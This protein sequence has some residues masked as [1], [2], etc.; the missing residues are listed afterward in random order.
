MHTTRTSTSV[1][2][3]KVFLITL[4]STNAV[5]QESQK[6]WIEH[7]KGDVYYSHNRIEHIKGDGS[8]FNSIFMVTEEGIILVDPID[9]EASKWLKNELK[10]RFDLPVRYIVYSHFHGDHAVGAEVFLDTVFEIY[11]QENTAANIQNDDT[12]KYAPWDQVKILP[13]KTYRGRTE[14]SLGT[15]KVELLDITA[16]HTDD[17]T[18]VRFPDE[19]IIFS[20]DVAPAGRVLWRYFGG[21]IVKDVNNFDLLLTDLETILALDFDIIAPGH[22]VHFPKQAVRQTYDYSVELCKRVAAEIKAGRN[23][24]QILETVT[25]ED[26]GHL[27]KYDSYRAMN[28]EGMHYWLSQDASNWRPRQCGETRG[29]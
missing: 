16:S 4:I 6:R 27:L 13:T 1:Q 9:V 5:A 26:Y 23:L 25:M 18:L 22:Y 21:F 17:T 11:A 24:S 28:V 29:L 3:L 2:V 8:I 10:E 14:I 7:I 20:V 19:R 12:W 15:K